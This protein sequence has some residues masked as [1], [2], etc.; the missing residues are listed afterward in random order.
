MPASEVKQL[1]IGLNFDHQRA[2]KNM[3]E[4]TKGFTSMTIAAEDFIS[5]SRDLTIMQE[6]LA[7]VAEATLAPFKALGKTIFD[8]GSQTEMALIRLGMF[9]NTLKRSAIDSFQIARQQAKDTLFSFDEV[10]GAVQDFAAAGIDAQKSFGEGF[11][12]AGGQVVK[13][14]KSLIGAITD[15]ASAANIDPNIIKGNVLQAIM[16]GRID[17]LQHWIGPQKT[18]LLQMMGGLQGTLQQK[19]EQMTNFLEKFY[20]GMGAKANA[21]FKA[22]V[23]NIKDMAGEVMSFFLDIQNPTAAYRQMVDSLYA[24]FQKVRKEYEKFMGYGEYRNKEEKEDYLKKRLSVLASVKE[25]LSPF[26]STFKAIVNSIADATNAIINFT[27]THPKLVAVLGKGI[28]IAGLLATA[29]GFA[30]AATSAFVALFGVVKNFIAAFSGTGVMMAGIFMSIM[31]GVE[32]LKEAWR[33]NFGN[34]RD[35]VESVGNTVVKW[36]NKIEGF[37]GALYDIF[38]TAS[39]GFAVVSKRHWDALADNPGLQKFLMLIGKLISDMRGFFSGELTG[40]IAAAKAWLTVLGPAIAAIGGVMGIRGLLKI[41]TSG[42]NV[43][44]SG[45]VVGGVLGSI[46]GIKQGMPVFV[47]NWPSGLAALTASTAA[48]QVSILSRLVTSIN[49]TN[50]VLGKLGWLGAALGVGYGIG[51][52]IEPYIPGSSSMSKE[53]SDAAYAKSYPKSLGMAASLFTAKNP[54]TLSESGIDKQALNNELIR[55]IGGIAPGLSYEKRSAMDKAAQEIVNAIDEAVKAA[56]KSVSPDMRNVGYIA[57]VEI[58]DGR[59]PSVRLVPA[60]RP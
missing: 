21:T 15:L 13:Y 30:V 2:V 41:F 25:I 17:Y 45:G 60:T 59:T 48:E 9:S 19:T 29:A 23:L 22:I 33:T 31:L 52:L 46:F 47:T 10:I 55:Y 8:L 18:M 43:A 27:A 12:H 35:I 51:S 56:S 34:I 32:T 53:E 24:S 42:G 58:Y 20:G 50:S 3:A 6:G 5:V 1:G 4:A 44:S 39:G 14:Q 28:G 26:V 54:L 16:N 57:K 38:K 11:A 40:P 7:R 49:G 36:W 37:F